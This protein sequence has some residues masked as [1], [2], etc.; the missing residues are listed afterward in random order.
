MA[1]NRAQPALPTPAKRRGRPPRPGGPTPQAEVQRAYRARLKAAGKI[2]K[3]IDPAVMPDPADVLT[4]RD[5]LHNAL[6]TSNRW[7]EEAARL[8]ASNLDL[9]DKVKVLEARSAYFQQKSAHFE[10]KYMSLQRR[11]EH[12]DLEAKFA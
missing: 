2:V 11:I 7:Q 8:E 9:E 5:E 4:M 1:K 10:S 6:S 12:L 3:L